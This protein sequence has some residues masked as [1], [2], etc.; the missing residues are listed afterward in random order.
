MAVLD[1]IV[2]NGKI[3]DVKKVKKTLEELIP[4]ATIEI[5]DNKV[6]V[7]FKDYSDVYDF[8]RP[9]RW[10]DMFTSNKMEEIASNLDGWLE[11]QISFDENEWVNMFVG[12]GNIIMWDDVD[13]IVIPKSIKDEE[14]YKAKAIELYQSYLD[15]LEHKV[16]RYKKIIKELKGGE[17]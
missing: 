17:K 15:E 2:F 6:K 8:A 1:Y 11:A 7:E 16:K 12:Y 4:E 13:K 9:M 5:E 10:M 3:R 14:R